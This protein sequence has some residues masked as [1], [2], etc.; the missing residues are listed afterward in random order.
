[1][2]YFTYLSIDYV[3]L[4]VNTIKQEFLSVWYQ[5]LDQ[6]L[7]CKRNPLNTYWMNIWHSCQKTTAHPTAQIANHSTLSCWVWP[8]TPN[9]LNITF[10]ATT[11]KAIRFGTQGE[12]CYPCIS[13]LQNKCTSI[14]KTGS[15]HS[16]VETELKF[17]IINYWLSCQVCL[18][19]S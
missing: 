5:H 16:V 9:F 14:S 19:I 8:R 10:Q 6:C 11:A 12:I 2:K 18:N 1:M 15:I 4:N 13:P 7:I 17:S 3:L